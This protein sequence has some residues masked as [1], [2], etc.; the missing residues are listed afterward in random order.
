MEFVQDNNRKS[1]Q[2]AVSKFL[3]WTDETKLIS[4]LSLYVGKKS[5]YP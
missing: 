3:A 4:K 5:F 1:Q 2:I